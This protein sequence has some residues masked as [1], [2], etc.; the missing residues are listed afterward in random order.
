MLDNIQD[1][2]GRT[3]H[4]L[5]LRDKEAGMGS[6][7]EQ[8]VKKVTKGIPGYGEAAAKSVLDP[9][10][11][12][13]IDDATEQ[14]QKRIAEKFKAMRSNVADTATPPPKNLDIPSAGSPPPLP[15]SNK[16]IGLD[17]AA[18]SRQDARHKS[19]MKQAIKDAK[20]A[21]KHTYGRDLDKGSIKPGDMGKLRQDLSAKYPELSS[22]DI[23]VLTAKHGGPGKVMEFLRKNP[24]KSAVA[25]T[26]GTAGVV[27]AANLPEAPG[28]DTIQGTGES[29][30]ED[31][32]T[33]IK[34]LESTFEQPVEKK[35]PSDEDKKETSS[36]GNWVDK[37]SEKGN[38]MLTSIQNFANTR[39][40]ATTIGGTTG[41]GLAY[42]ADRLLT[43]DD[44]E[45]DTK[46]RRLLMTLLGGALGAGAGYGIQAMR[47]K[48]AS[49]GNDV[50]SLI[51]QDAAELSDEELESKISNLE[52]LE[53]QASAESWILDRLKLHCK[54]A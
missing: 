52:S 28:Q 49:D 22:R 39:T 24:K 43:K 45:E 2:I 47:Q 10:L 15:T 25:G 7:G 46:G 27:G 8:A 11:V 17:P 13:S 51:R 40:G 4:F 30:A 1:F 36:N 14:A 32:Q 54:V 41:A 26:L 38:N 23:D 3:A 31:R 37:L 44:E 5:S 21:R 35:G 6:V 20:F 50:R 12:K 34:D 48:S 29:T 19:Q 42:L 33:L 18:V 53:K 9:R 16:K